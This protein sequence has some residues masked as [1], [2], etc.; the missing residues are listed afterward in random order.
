[1][2]FFCNTYPIK[3][4][5]S[6][7]TSQI[8]APPWWP[9]VHENDCLQWWFPCFPWSE[10][11]KCQYQNAARVASIFY[12]FQTFHSFATIL[13]LV[14]KYLIWESCSRISS[15]HAAEPET[16]SNIHGY[17]VVYWCSFNELTRIRLFKGTTVQRRCCS[18][19]SMSF[20]IF[21]FS[22]VRLSSV[23]FVNL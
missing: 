10:S 12:A 17:D 7:S 19:I 16:S 9:M 23:A 5:A 15:M 14:E 4:N 3:S 6:F 18:P 22:R 2:F 1:M 20:L 21:F 8:G 13:E 11:A